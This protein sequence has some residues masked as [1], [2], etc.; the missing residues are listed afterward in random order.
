LRPRGSGAGN[1]SAKH[2]DAP[3]SDDAVHGGI[4]TNLPAGFNLP[5][6]IEFASIR[7][8][9]VTALGWVRSFEATESASIRG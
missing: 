4:M 3:Q 6:H 5:I 2:R 1:H 9:R 7:E 8:I